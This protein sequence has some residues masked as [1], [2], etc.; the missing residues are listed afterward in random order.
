MRMAILAMLLVV[1]GCASQSSVSDIS[2][3]TLEAEEAAR[4]RI[5]LGLTYLQNGNYAQAKRNLDRANE[6]APRLA[7]VQYSLA[8]YFQ[9]VGEVDQA[10]SAYQRAI[11]LGPTNAD[12]ANSYGAFLCEQGN[13]EAAKDFFL[14]AI[15]N[16]R[17]A[18]AADSYENLA[19]CANSNGDA[20]AAIDYFQQSLNHQPGRAKTL[21]LLTEMYIQTSQWDLAEAT[22]RKYEKTAPVSAEL[23]WKWME[24]YKGKGDQN[25]ALGYGDMLLTMYPQHLLTQR[26]IAQRAQLAPKMLRTNKSVEAVVEVVPESRQTNTALPVLAQAVP[27]GPD[28]A[29]QG[30]DGVQQ[31]TQLPLFH[32]VEKE[33]NLYRISLKYNVKIARLREWNG[34]SQ[35]ST[36]RPG[37]KLWLV[38]PK[39][40]TQ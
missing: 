28:V 10:D 31:G 13:Y 2:P 29:Q 36:I 21:Y 14:K 9:T 33:E 27:Q 24:I 6:Y 16:S 25:T 39:E 17:Y 22:L 35:E 38:P 7:E 40:Q 26:F 32:I 11:A 34:L 3:G 8:Y 23:L 12:I 20:A 37:M 15:N 4:T 5:S 1:G 30:H 18:S 19:L